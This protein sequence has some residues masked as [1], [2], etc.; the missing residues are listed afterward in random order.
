MDTIN[1][2]V[3][4]G[5]AIVCHIVMLAGYSYELVLFSLGRVTANRQED[6]V[7]LAVIC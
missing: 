1:S 3:R 7:D 2:F 4:R 6:E 5:R